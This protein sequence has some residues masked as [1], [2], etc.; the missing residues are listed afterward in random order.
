MQVHSKAEKNNPKNFPSH[1]NSGGR[2]MNSVPRAIRGSGA[3][4]AKDHHNRGENKKFT[5]KKDKN[6]PSSDAQWSKWN[7]TG[8]KNWGHDDRFNKDY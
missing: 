7:D 1:P 2:P 8:S 3:T 4:D 5:V 6:S